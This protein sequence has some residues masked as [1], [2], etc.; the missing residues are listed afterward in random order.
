MTA[1]P[2]GGWC[3]PAEVHCA[4]GATTWPHD[5]TLPPRVPTVA[6]PSV[7]GQRGFRPAKPGDTPGA[8]EPDD[9]R[10]QPQV[11]GDPTVTAVVATL[12]Q[13]AGWGSSRPTTDDG[14]RELADAVLIG[15]TADADE[16]DALC[17]PMCEEVVCDGGCPLAPVRTRP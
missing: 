7:A 10:P 16:L 15:C 11:L 4:C 3:A 14:W 1:D 12:R 13:I 6:L 8:V 2:T 17:C 9:A 5:C